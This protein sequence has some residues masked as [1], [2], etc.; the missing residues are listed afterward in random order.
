LEGDYKKYLD[1]KAIPILAIASMDSKEKIRHSAQALLLHIN[2]DWQNSE[3][4]LEA[5]PQLMTK[6][7]SSSDQTS[8][9][10]AHLLSSMST[11]A[12]PELVQYIRLG[13][14][15]ILQ[16]K[17]IQI[18]LQTEGDIDIAVP[19]LIEAL[20]SENSMVRELSI[21]TLAKAKH[22]S[23]EMLSKLGTCLEDS[24]TNICLAAINTLSKHDEKAGLLSRPLVKLLLHQKSEIRQAAKET[25]ITIGEPALAD[26][27]QLIEERND[28]RKLE[29]QR[30]QKTK[31]DLFKGMDIN[32]FLLEPYHS[33]RNVSWHVNDILL[34]LDKIEAGIV[35]AIEV[36]AHLGPNA[37]AAID[38]LQNTLTE[39]NPQIG[40][41]SIL[42]LGAIVQPN[43]F[44][45]ESG[46]AFLKHLL[47]CLEYENK[48]LSAL[49]ALKALPSPVIQDLSQNHEISKQRIAPNTMKLLLVLGQNAQTALPVLNKIIEE[50]RQLLLEKETA[51]KEKRI[52]FRK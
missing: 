7:K 34:E 50:E 9:A 31:G 32:K 6:L 46:Q 16:W 26:L 22:C 24:N 45:A 27:I 8:N 29:I 10:A 25:L 13:E 52:G 4:V 11:K 19:A 20:D 30:L 35:K 47:V 21:K 40:T 14:H 3:S 42:A 28:L 1:E 51:K 23:S 48:R 33:V 43:W 2:Q 17:V 37:Q 38:V 41:Q 49:V 12:L 18:V 36:L 5:I 44:K 15:E 39:A